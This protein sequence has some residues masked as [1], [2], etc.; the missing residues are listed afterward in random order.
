M[1]SITHL[2][3]GALCGAVY[4]RRAEA[5]PL[6]AMAAFAVLALSPDLDLLSVAT[7]LRGT[8]LD[9]RAATHSLTVSLVVGA[10]VGAVAA[11]PGHRRL[12]G[13]LCVLALA[14]H[15]GLDALTRTEPAPQLL[16]PFSS[17]A[18]GAAWQP[19]P[20]TRSYQEYFTSAALPVYAWEAVW[21]APLLAGAAWV[22]LRP[23]RRTGPTSAGS[24]AVDN[25]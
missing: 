8:P 5:K 13:L 12:A 11:E 23:R 24:L 21:C 4:A 10:L 1:A 19:I 9:H 6:P 22:L 20:G 2:A 14:S 7:G 16:W 15:A 3:A 18:I 17:A 25:D